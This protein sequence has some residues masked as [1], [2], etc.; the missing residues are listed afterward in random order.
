MQ[1]DYRVQL[2]AFQGPL[3]LLLYLIR[4]HEVDIHDIPIA[5]VT[6]QY[7]G[8]IADLSRVDIDLA[9]EFLVVAA[10]L[11]EIKSRMIAAETERA[12]REKRGGQGDEDA[13]EPPRPRSDPRFE[14][15]QQLLEYKALR[16]AADE[17]ERRRETWQQRVPVR[18]AGVPAEEMREA[19]E[20]MEDDLDLEDL[21]LADI[22]AAFERI[23][24]T[25]NMDRLGEHEVLSDDTPIELHAEDLMDRLRT[26]RDDGGQLSLFDV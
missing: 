26:E 1:A 23:A 6:E 7:L 13:A 14:L 18:P 25:V 8:H 21:N 4:R 9:G 5:M 12:D 20:S 11:M 10:T 22:M 16:D 17:L 24:A 3:D 19:F 15:V 2:D